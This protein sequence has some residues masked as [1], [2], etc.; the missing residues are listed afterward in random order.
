MNHLVHIVLI[1][2]SAIVAMTWLGFSFQFSIQ[3]VINVMF[4]A[5]PYLY[6]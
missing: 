5:G 3:G 2:A 6:D 1:L 4:D